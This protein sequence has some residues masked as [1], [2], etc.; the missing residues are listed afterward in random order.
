MLNELKPVKGARTAPKRIGRGPASGTGGTSGKGSKGQ[1]AR[2]G[3]GVRPGFE[4]GQIPF[5]QR[6]PKRGF[7]CPSRKE[8][9]IVSTSALNVFGDGATITPEMLLEK[10]I[11]TKYLSGVKI[12]SDGKLTAKN[13]TVKANKYSKSALSEIEAAGGKIEVI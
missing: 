10:R 13:L 7:N 12:L 5:F 6:F 1:N 9:A 3:G 4:G 8:F 11:I 2:S